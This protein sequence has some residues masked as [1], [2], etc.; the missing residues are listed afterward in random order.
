MAPKREAEAV[1]WS[2]GAD[3]RVPRLAQRRVILFFCPIRASSANQI[4]IGLPSTACA[5]SSKR[6]GKFFKSRHRGLALGVMARTGRELAIVHGAQLPAKRLLGNRDAELLP[7]PLD[8]IDQ[9][10][11]HH[12]M[13]R[14]DRTLVD[15]GHQGRAMRVGE[16]GRLAGRLA[17]D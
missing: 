17:V 2:L 8:E 13:D 4:S 14:R 5:I 9:A 15:P 11:A 10:P 16:L 7:E 6:A 12:A 1:L 3:G